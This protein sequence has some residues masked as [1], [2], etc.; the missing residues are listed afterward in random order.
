MP[1]NN[2][3]AEHILNIKTQEPVISSINPATKGL[4]IAANIPILPDIPTSDPVYLGPK[5]A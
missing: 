5:S 1:P 2:N 3:A 4:I